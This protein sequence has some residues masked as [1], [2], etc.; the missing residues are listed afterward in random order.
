MEFLTVNSSNV[1]EMRPK[2]ARKQCFIKFW[3]D[4]CG[5]CVQMAPE[6]EAMKRQLSKDYVSP[7][8]ETAIVEVDA[9]ASTQIP[10]GKHVSGFPTIMHASNGEL[11]E[12]YSG[13][14]TAQAMKTWIISNARDLEHKSRSHKTRRRRRG[15]KGRKRGKSRV[16]RRGRTKGRKRR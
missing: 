15:T 5:H 4:G 9:P 2:V 16:K 13:P 6:W 7:G 8:G 12:T 1:R 14:R 10:L 11:V 3:M